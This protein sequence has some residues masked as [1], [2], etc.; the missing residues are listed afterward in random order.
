MTNPPTGRLVTTTTG[1]DLILTRSFR[2]GLDDVWA[3]VTEPERSARW[4]GRWT[5]EGGTGNSIKVQLAFEE[6]APWMEMRIDACEPPRRLAVTSLGEDGWR[7]ELQ[8][9]AAGDRTELRLIHHLPS[10]DGVGEVGPGWEYYL[11]LLVAARD[12]S[13]RPQFD[14]YYPS[15]KDYFE[16][17]RP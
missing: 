11:D 5:G 16:G 12:G 9:E 17:L 6:G 8:L 14:D 1:F 7:L 3:G 13:P 15:M 10:A 2:A 4:F